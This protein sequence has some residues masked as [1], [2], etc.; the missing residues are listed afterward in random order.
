[1]RQPITQI[2]S[3][4][5]FKCYKNYA[6]RRDFLN[7]IPAHSDYYNSLPENYKMRY[8]SS[9]ACPE[10]IGN[11]YNFIYSIYTARVKDVA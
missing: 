10:V 5:F 9:A 6:I 1:M 3:H 4:F 7:S 8:I 2:Y 11:C